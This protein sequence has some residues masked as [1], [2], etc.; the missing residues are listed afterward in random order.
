MGLTKYRKG[1]L[2]EDLGCEKHGI[3]C[4]GNLGRLRGSFFFPG[5]FFL[6]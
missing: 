2:L 3:H 5:L 1:D 4:M 6:F